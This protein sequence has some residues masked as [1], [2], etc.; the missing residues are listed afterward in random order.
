MA[1]AETH[2]AG[3]PRLIGLDWGSSS[4]RAYLIGGDGS[5]LQHRGNDS[6]ASRLQGDK[7]GFES[8]LRGLIG[9]WLSDQAGLPIV[10]CGMVGSAH[11]W[12]E[13][14]YAFCPLAL[15]DLQQQ[16]VTVQ[17]SVQASDR[18]QVRIVPGIAQRPHGGV[19]DVMR[20]EETQVAGL[21]ATNPSLA[22]QALVIMPGTHSKWVTLRDGRMLSF[23]TRMTGEVFALLR[24]QSVLARLIEPADDFY[25]E[26]FD[27]GVAHG[28]RDHGTDLLGRL[29]SVRTRGLFEELPPSALADYLSGLLI[30][31]EVA[32]GLADVASQ[33]KHVAIVLV[34]EAALCDRYQRA[35]RNLGQEAGVAQG[36]PAVAGLWRMAERAG[37]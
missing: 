36:N 22:E 12:K 11:G 6:G 20:G 18:L 17:G 35:L 10:A 5:V 33:A 4:L 21:L 29:F 34:G 27:Q 26:A 13:A 7:P 16:A 8:A 25:A 32:A 30:G 14:P 19:P 15:D 2:P 24:S 9:D 28:S 3:A 37:W 1:A 31:S 23:T